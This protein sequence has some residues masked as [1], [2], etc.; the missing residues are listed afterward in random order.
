MI[1]LTISYSDKDELSKVMSILKG[2]IL[3]MKSGKKGS[4]YFKAYVV[5]DDARLNNCINENH[6][7]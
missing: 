4:K 2:Y 3:E 5:L 7:T 1:K 6:L